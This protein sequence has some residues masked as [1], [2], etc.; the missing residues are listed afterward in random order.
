MIYFGTPVSHPILALSGGLREES[1]PTAKMTDIHDSQ[2]FWGISLVV[3]RELS[4]QLLE[5][6]ELS[7]SFGAVFYISTPHFPSSILYLQTYRW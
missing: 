2:V 5:I 1:S 3:I 4:W 7:A 6:S